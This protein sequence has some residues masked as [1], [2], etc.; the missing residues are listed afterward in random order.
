LVHDDAFGFLVGRSELR[1]QADQFCTP[2]RCRKR[3]RK[4]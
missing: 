1:P 2:A 4:M 3:I